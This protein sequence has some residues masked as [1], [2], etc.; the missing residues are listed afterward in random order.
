ME[1]AQE[2]RL[3]YPYRPPGSRAPTGPPV[4]HRPWSTILLVLHTLALI[5][6]VLALGI[7]VLAFVANARPAPE[8]SIDLAFAVGLVFGVAGLVVCV[9]VGFLRRMTVAGRR[10]ADQGRARAIRNAGATTILVAGLGAFYSL[11][12][13]F[14]AGLVACCL[15]ALPAVFLLRATNEGAVGSDS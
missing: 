8:G 7:A 4:P 2:I 5:A 3:P 14:E 13:S 6:A 12:F 9:S 11:R 1:D 10:E 15:Y